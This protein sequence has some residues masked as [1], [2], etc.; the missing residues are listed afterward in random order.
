MA[1][2]ELQQAAP[3]ETYARRAT[4]TA[5]PQLPRPSRRVATALTVLGLAMIPWL[6]VLHTGLPA[7]AQASHW[8]WTWTG[9]DTLEA[10]GLLSTGLLLR[11]GDQRACLTAAATST[12]LLIDAW[13]DTM[14][15]TPGTDLL[16]AE[17]MAAFVELPLA[18]AC[19]T[20][21]IR[22]FP[23]FS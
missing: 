12:L 19:A 23:R 9:L 3:V 11:R 10:I 16:T 5:A 20:L 21:A 13:F 7:T 22:T 8:A 18:A 2:A 15:A 4:D 6:F 17:L 1:L 14:T